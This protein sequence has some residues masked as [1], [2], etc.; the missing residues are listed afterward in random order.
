M[1]RRAFPADRYVDQRATLISQSIDCFDL[2]LE[3]VVFSVKISHDLDG[4][5]VF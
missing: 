5:A 3:G 4:I 2:I 1:A